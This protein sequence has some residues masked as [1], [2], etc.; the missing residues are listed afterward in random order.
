MLGHRL[1]K[2]KV[3]TMKNLLHRIEKVSKQIGLSRKQ[4]V[5][6]IIDGSCLPS[7]IFNAHEEHGE[8][9]NWRCKQVAN[10]YILH[11]TKCVYTLDEGDIQKHI[12]KFRNRTNFETVNVTSDG[13][14]IMILNKCIANK[15]GINPGIMNK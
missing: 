11:G 9:I 1:L 5:I 4:P 8:Y 14:P 3:I 7:K 10:D 2:L 13:N 15:N 6:L 12:K